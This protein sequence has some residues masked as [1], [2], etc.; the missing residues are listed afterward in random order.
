MTNLVEGHY[1][2]GKRDGG[3]VW[4]LGTKDWR[5]CNHTDCRAE[6]AEEVRHD[7]LL[8]AIR[9]AI[10]YLATTP[11][12]ASALSDETMLPNHIVQVFEDHLK[13][14]DTGTV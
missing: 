10:P 3:S 11:A 14:Y 2:W 6:R 13:D 7:R 1:A 4:H 8:Q 12:R 9:E 5:E